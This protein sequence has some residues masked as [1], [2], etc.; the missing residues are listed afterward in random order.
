MADSPLRYRGIEVVVDTTIP[1][2]FD[3]AGYRLGER[4]IE[5]VAK[6]LS[7][8][9]FS[10]DDRTVGPVRIREIEDMILSIS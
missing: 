10:R 6:Q 8:V 3:I 9:T 1:A 5:N 4:F 2:E 7:E